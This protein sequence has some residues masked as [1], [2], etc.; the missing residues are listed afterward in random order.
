MIKF[1]LV[2]KLEFGN[3]IN[4]LAYGSRLNLLKTDN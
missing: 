4:S 2:P 1:F 3:E